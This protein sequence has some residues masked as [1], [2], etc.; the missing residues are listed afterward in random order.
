MEF[1]KNDVAPLAAC[2]C[3]A[4][5][6][7]AWV[8]RLARAVDVVG[9]KA[10]CGIGNALSARERK[11]VACAGWQTVDPDLV[12]TVAPRRHRQ[13]IATVDL[14]RDLLFLRGPET[15]AYPAFLERRA[16]LPLQHAFFHSRQPAPVSNPKVNEFRQKRFHKASSQFASLGSSPGFLFR[17]LGTKSGYGGLQAFTMSIWIHDLRAAGLRAQGR[18]ALQVLVAAILHHRK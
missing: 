17:A 4:P 6:I 2:P 18:Q 8:Y 13:G 15:K 3:L 7:G 12:K 9:L 1:V 5:A 10:R 14:Q 16:V 11:H